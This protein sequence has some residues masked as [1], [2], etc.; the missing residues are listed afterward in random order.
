M[1]E[2]QLQRFS[3]VHEDILI[4]VANDTLAVRNAKAA[5]NEQAS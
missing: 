3:L 4:Y 5:F 2:R 1:F